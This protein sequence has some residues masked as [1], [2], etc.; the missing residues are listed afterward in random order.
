MG[1]ILELKYIH[2]IAQTLHSPLLSSLSD[3]SLEVCLLI[4]EEPDMTLS[5]EIIRELNTIHYNYQYKL[6]RSP[7]K[8]KEFMTGSLSNY[9]F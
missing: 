1:E 2:K 5:D 8:E 4:Q 7:S 3:S 9:V 6:P